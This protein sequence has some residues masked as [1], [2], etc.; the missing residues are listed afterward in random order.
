MRDAQAYLEKTMS[1]QSVI[2]ILRSKILFHEQLNETNETID[3]MT[4][5]R[6]LWLNEQI[7]SKAFIDSAFNYDREKKLKEQ[8]NSV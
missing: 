1:P 5:D 4:M 3:R 7:E 8:E 2:D 6:L